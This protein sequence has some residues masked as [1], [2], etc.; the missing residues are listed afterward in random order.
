MRT[1][2]ILAAATVSLGLGL[3]SCS[4]PPGPVQPM[5]GPK[6]P[7]VYVEDPKLREWLDVPAE[8]QNYAFT[9]LGFLEYNV[10]IRNK[11]SR[12]MALAYGY[13]CYDERGQ[14]VENVQLAERIFVKQN[15]EYPLQVTSTTK[16]AKTMRIQIRPA[17]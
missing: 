17:D 16:D 13:Y 7:G 6:A 4:N 12:D 2:L 14:L 3:S 8:Q 9:K 10:V 15:S 11:G 5:V 1:M